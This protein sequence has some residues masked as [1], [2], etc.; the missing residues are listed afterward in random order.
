MLALG[1][2][3]LITASPIGFFIAKL[4]G[5]VFLIWLVIRGWMN[6]TKSVPVSERPARQVYLHALAVATINPKSVAGYL[7]AFSQFV[8]PGLSIWQQ[9]S[10]IMPTALVVTTLS[11]TG[12]TLLGALMGR[13]AMGVVFNTR[14]RRVIAICFIF[15]GVLLGISSAPAARG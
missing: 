14:V 12:F 5:A 2:T 1:V 3:V 15:Y 6:A 13:A 11:Y 10:M 8:Q 4:I 7:A 9:M